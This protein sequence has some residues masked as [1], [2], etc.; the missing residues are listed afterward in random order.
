MR[1]DGLFLIYPTRQTLV[2]SKITE[3]RSTS[4]LKKFRLLKF[5]SPLKPNVPSK[6]HFLYAV[7]MYEQIGQNFRGWFH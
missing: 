6:G 2:E 5:F 3:N 7:T 4:A 1:I